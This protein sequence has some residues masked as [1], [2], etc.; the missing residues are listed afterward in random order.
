MTHDRK[1][2]RQVGD[3]NGQLNRIKANEVKRYTD[4]NQ[5]NVPAL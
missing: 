2:D 5:G 3:N 4:C 1:P